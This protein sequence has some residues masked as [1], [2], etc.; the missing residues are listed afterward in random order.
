MTNLPAFFVPAMVTLAD[1]A[2]IGAD[3]LYKKP[4][5]SEAQIAGYK[6]ALFTAEEAAITS[7]NAEI[8]KMPA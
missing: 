8:A 1:Q 6:T 7:I 5:A 4:A 3:V 2:E